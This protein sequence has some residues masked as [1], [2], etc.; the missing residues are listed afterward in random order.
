MQHLTLP[1]LQCKLLRVRTGTFN[2]SLSPLSSDNINASVTH[3]AAVAAAVAVAVTAAA[4]AAAA[5]AAIATVYCRSESGV[6][7][8]LVLF[9][10][11]IRHSKAMPDALLEQRAT[12]SGSASN[13]FEGTWPQQH[14]P[15]GAVKPVETIRLKDGSLADIAV[16]GEILFT[17]CCLCCSC[18]CW[19]H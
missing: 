4:A 6:L 14:M 15:P 1:L 5:I 2:I 18:G 7:S 11:M 12:S 17:S 8:Q 3:A 19:Q 16:V 10:I 13:G 9:T